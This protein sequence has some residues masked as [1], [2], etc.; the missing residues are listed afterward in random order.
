MVGGT[1]RSFRW[2]QPRFQGILCCV[3][4][5]RSSCKVIAYSC[6]I[7]FSVG[8]WIAQVKCSLAI[9]HCRSRD[10]RLRNLFLAKTGNFM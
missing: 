7:D 6:R 1:S 2:I 10:I 5:E 4:R 3:L 8:S 9:H